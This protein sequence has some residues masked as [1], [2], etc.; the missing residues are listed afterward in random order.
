MIRYVANP[1][2]EASKALELRLS[3]QT[4][5]ALLNRHVCLSGVMLGGRD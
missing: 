4:C 5:Q 3:F 2:H 1:D